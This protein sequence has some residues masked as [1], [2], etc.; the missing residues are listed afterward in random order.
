[1]FA[2]R[3]PDGSLALRVEGPIAPV[4]HA[5]IE[6]SVAATTA[7]FTRRLEAAIRRYPDQ[8]NWLGLP[9]QG[10]RP[11]PA[12]LAGSRRRR[13]TKNKNAPSQPS[14]IGSDTSAPR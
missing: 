1:M 8:W 3:R 14:R 5:D 12:A 6:Q 9:R 2:I 4:E 7:L 10:H 13:R 11:A